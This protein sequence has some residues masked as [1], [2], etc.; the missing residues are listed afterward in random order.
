[1]HEI[2]CGE[3]AGFPERGER[4]RSRRGKGK[5]M[6]KYKASKMEMDWKTQ[7]DFENFST[8]LH[9]A[10]QSGNQKA[11]LEWVARMAAFGPDWEIVSARGGLTPLGLAAW[12]GLEEGCAALIEAG[13]DPEF[14][15]ESAEGELV[16]LVDLA[17]GWA[18]G[19]GSKSCAALV[20]A[21][22][23]RKGL[24]REALRVGSAAPRPSRRSM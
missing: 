2:L 18:G 6:M 19:K 4:K 7:W 5:R 10:K 17:E 14:S 21:A 12:L 20:L 22:L 3:A 23:E 15:F 11:A 13:A 16:D 24:A 9:E 8:P 1:M